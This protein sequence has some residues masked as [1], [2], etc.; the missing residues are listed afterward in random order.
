MAFPFNFIQLV[1]EI[2]SNIAF[3]DGIGDIVKDKILIDIF[4]Y[5]TEFIINRDL[6]FANYENP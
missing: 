2:H 5:N 6:K 4:E 1:S 3:D